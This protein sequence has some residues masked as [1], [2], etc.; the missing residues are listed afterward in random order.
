MNS[1][2]INVMNSDGGVDLDDTTAAAAKSAGVAANNAG[3]TGGKIRG[4]TH[5]WIK[6]VLCKAGV[7]SITAIRH[8]ASICKVHYTMFRF[9]GIKDKYALTMQEVTS[10]VCMYVCVYVCMC[11]RV[12]VC[13]YVCVCVCVCMYVCMCVCV[14][15]CMFRFGGN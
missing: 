9:A 10:R 3:K 5:P 13:V 8:I 15:V 12:C 1:D 14:Y 4:G 6:F 7:D 11:M 2:G